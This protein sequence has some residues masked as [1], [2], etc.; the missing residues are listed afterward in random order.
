MGLTLSDLTSRLET[1]R[2]DLATDPL[3]NP[4]RRLSHELSKS[5][6]A[7]ELS[8]DDTHTMIGELSGEAARARMAQGE[9]YLAAGGALVDA[10]SATVD[11]ATDLEALQEQVG[12]P[13][14]TIVFTGHPTFAMGSEGGFALRGSA[15]IDEATSIRDGIKLSDEHQEASRALAA[16]ADAILQ[17]NRHLLRKAEERFGDAFKSVLPQLVG[18]ATWVGYDLDGRQDIGWVQIFRHRLAEKASALHHYAETLKP[19][20]G[21]A[22]VDGV[23][24][25]LE[26]ALERAEADSARFAD[27]AALAT[28]EGVAA[29]ANALTAEGEGRLTSIR[30][31]I[32][33]LR[34]AAQAADKDQAIAILAVAGLMSVRGLGLGEIHFRLNA[35]Q[36]R[37]AARSLLPIPREADLFGH[38]ALS[39]VNEAVSAVEPVRVNFG[40]LA[41]ETSSARRIA[42]TAAQILKHVDEDT[43]IRLLIAE[44]ENPV[45][46]LTAVYLTKRFGVDGKV[47]VCPLFETAQSFDRSRRILSVLLAQPCYR[48]QVER[49]GRVSIEAGFSDAGRFM[50]QLPAT[51]A[52]E[53]LQGQLAREMGRQ[54][55]SHLEAV[56]FN[57][58]G[59]SMG[60]GGHPG[61]ILERSRYAMSPW[62]RGRFDEAGVRL[63]HEISFQGG[64]GYAWFASP[65]AAQSVLAGLLTAR[66][67]EPVEDPFYQRTE[68]SLD[69]YN[70]VRGVQ[71]DLFHEEAMATV[72]MGPG[73]ALLPP[74]GSRKT[75]RQFERSGEEEISLRRIRAISHNGSLQQI[76]YVAN[77]HAGVGE[78]IATEPEAYAELAQT[79][80]RF[81]RLMTLVAKAASLSDMK[82]LIAYMKLYDGSFWATRPISGGEVHL[83]RA[84][85][86]LA[87][88]LVKDR[89]YF[90]ALELAAHLRPGAIK[91]KRGLEQMGFDQKGQAPLNL[92]L[93]HALRLALLQ[94]MFLLGARLP[95]FARAGGFSRPEVL[96]EIL[97]LDVPRAVEQLRQG[98]PQKSATDMQS[99]FDEP[100]DEDGTDTGYEAIERETIAP[101]ERA[102][103]QCRRISLAIAHHF[104]AHG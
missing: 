77:L 29:V 43:P 64:D 67:N 91:L 84:C 25:R 17:L 41:S 79:S 15:A 69:F 18:L 35:S 72:A 5:I 98:F 58:H 103:E 49:R 52:I 13:V 66:I 78:A 14:E 4:V 23:V 55:L 85:G 97:A 24:A 21:V 6:E 12:R 92:D 3:A 44:C 56:I 45:T 93:L 2:G 63:G 27:D 73:L 31:L 94:H 95:S 59:E 26:A 65:E 100:A 88:H 7:G 33:G 1:L 82:T 62:A 20:A 81:R 46:V 71:L 8:L 39:I 11:A 22:S 34:E 102:F 101:L 51:L 32:D 53:R 61:S 80:D 36:I 70:T 28:P 104:G 54:G 37:N 86:D 74:A 90:A 48:E 89:R 19:L 40:S 38:S 9:A 16:A 10:V 87:A 57:T 47:D 96:N 75:K 68:A 42:I 76:G 60:R 83:E 30:P 50:G 99:L